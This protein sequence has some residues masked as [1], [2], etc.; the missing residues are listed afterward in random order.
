MKLFRFALIVLF[1]C[2]VPTLAM[3]Q[4]ATGQ[5]DNLLDVTYRFSWYPQEDLQQLLAEKGTEYGQTLE[6]YRDQLRQDLQIETGAEDRIDGQLTAE[7]QQ[8]KK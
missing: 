6:G 2:L 5:W 3:S 4:T 8:W 7:G 1:V